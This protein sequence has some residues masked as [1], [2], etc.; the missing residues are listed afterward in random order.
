MAWGA[1]GLEFG[2][3]GVACLFIWWV[4]VEFEQ[5]SGLA[6]DAFV[7][8]CFENDP[9]LACGGM[10]SSIGCI[11]WFPADVVQHQAYERLVEPLADRVVRDRCA[12][13]ERGAIPA[14]MYHDLGA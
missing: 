2:G 12:V 3:D 5:A 14:D 13:V 7:I 10:A 4:V 8:V 1:A 9:F 11:D 6:V